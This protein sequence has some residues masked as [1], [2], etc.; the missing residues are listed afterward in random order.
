MLIQTILGA[1]IAGSIAGIYNILKNSEETEEEISIN[2]IVKYE[3]F[4]VEMHDILEDK[5][6]IRYQYIEG[7]KEG[8]NFYL[9]N[10][11]NNEGE[12]VKIDILDGNI[13]IGGMTGTGKSNIVNVL[14]T[15]LMLTYTPN[16][17]SFLGCDL[18]DSDVSYFYKYRHFINMS[19][20]HSGFLKQVE[21]LE[22]KYKERMKILN[23]A[24]CRNVVSYNKKNNKKMTYFVFAIDEVVLLTTNNE[25]KHKLHEIMCHGRKAGIY[26]IL[27]LQDATKDTI[28]K[29]KM[30]CPQ[31]IGLKTNDETD[32]NTI[33]GKNQ[34]LQ[35]I[36]VVGRC[37]VKTKNGVTEVQSFYIE[38][39]EMERLL[40]HNLKD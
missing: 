2:N 11:V 3:Y 33:I 8:L 21:W 36:N 1:T 9:G 5:N 34:N 28:G 20:T 30:N 27:C 4:P 14:I 19:T 29:C 24:N 16:E 6:I 37:K 17:V 31:V 23:E 15:S 13:L 40:K 22:N 25:C 12:K 10:D 39:D 7:E 32:S 26:F 18:A 35:D 38:E